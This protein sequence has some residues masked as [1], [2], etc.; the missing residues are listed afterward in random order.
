VYEE[1]GGAGGWQKG[2]GMWQ[3]WGITV[4]RLSESECMLTASSVLDSATG[5]VVE[6]RLDAHGYVSP[7]SRLLC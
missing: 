1:F 6:E 7:S 4:C 3:G 2:V 5:K